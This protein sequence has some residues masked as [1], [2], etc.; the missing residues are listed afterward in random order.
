MGDGD[1]ELIARLVR[2]H[3]AHAF[4]VLYRRHT[5]ALYASALRI[6]ADPDL[7]ADAVHDAWV[8]AVENLGRFEGRSAFRTWLTGILINCIRA[9]WRD[10]R[11]L[12]SIDAIGEAAPAP[13]R[14]PMDVD[15]MD[16][17]AAIV[18]LPPGYRC[19][20]VL[21]DVEGFSHEE[22]ATMLGIVPGTSKSQLARAR[23]KLREALTSDMRRIIP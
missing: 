11:D 15:P 21:H 17:H 10:E 20:V 3:D 18:A 2:R 19:V 22:I 16:L 6:A 1:A 7:A 5:D 23:N 13:A 8:R 4:D 9:R 12:V 14:L